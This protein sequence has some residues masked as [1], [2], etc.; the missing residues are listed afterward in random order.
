VVINLDNSLLTSDNKVVGTPRDQTDFWI[1][2]LL[3]LGLSGNLLVSGTYE[4][5]NPPDTNFHIFL[6]GE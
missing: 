2:R 6:V 1:E 3:K 5:M 4:P